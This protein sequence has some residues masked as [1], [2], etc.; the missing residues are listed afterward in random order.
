MDGDVPQVIEGKHGQSK[1]P[2]IVGL[3][4]NGLIVGEPA[5]EHL[6]REPS[7]TVYSVKR[8]M[9][10]SLADVSEELKYF[11]YALQEKGGVIRIQIGEKTYSPPQVSAMILKELKL[12]AEAHLGEEITKA[13]ITVPAYFNDSQ[14]QAT[15]DAG[16]IAGLEVLRIVNEPTAAS[17]AYGL[18][19]K[20]QGV[21]AIYDLGG[22]T[23]DI[24]LLKLKDGIFEVLATNGNTHLG[25]DDIDRCL[26]RSII[27]EINEQYGVKVEDYSDL[28]QIVRLESE[29]VKI[30]LSSDEKASVSFTLPE[31]AGTY[32]REWSR[33]ELESLTESLVKQTLLPCRLA[34]Q[35]AGLQASDVD[36]VV[37]VGGSTRMPLVRRMVQELFGMVPHCELNPDEVVALGAAVQAGILAGDNKDMLLLDVTPLSLGIETMGGVMSTLIRRNTTIPSSAKEMFTTYVDGQTSVDIHILQG[38]RELVKDN[39]SLA[40]FQL[41]VPPLPPAVPRVEV[42]FLI[43]ANG[44]L[45]VTAADIR[46]GESQTV[47]VKPS[48]GLTDDEVEGMIRESFQFAAQDIKV[49][50]AIEARTEA[51]AILFAT[52]KALKRGTALITLDEVQGI[53]KALDELRQAKGQD[54]HRVIREK[55]ADVEKVT[56]HLAEVLMDA[57]LKEALENKKLSE[58][59]D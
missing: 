29:R 46:T 5:K 19:K 47:Q 26:V 20:T 49:R 18:Q 30:W 31:G 2:S 27:Q 12:C 32:T 54:D 10:K 37:L 3:T 28:M 56:H 39:R 11:P 45:N 40:R 7:K 4:D 48:H 35:D 16:L 8:F 24:S 36:E 53:D 41:K 42:T 21:V 55:I 43:D 13:V 1:V 9:G 17:L 58:V 14:R 59:A 23:F 51:D 52:E 33:D 25:G 44:I 6:V 50:Q 57:T 38:E 15:K 22:G 34:L